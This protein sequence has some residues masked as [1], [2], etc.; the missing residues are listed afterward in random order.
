MFGQAAK[1][2]RLLQ[3]VNARADAIDAQACAEDGDKEKGRE[4]GTRSGGETLASLPL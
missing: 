1:N 3:R 2:R 4:E